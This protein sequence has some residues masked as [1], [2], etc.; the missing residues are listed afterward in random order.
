[1]KPYKYQQDSIIEILEG[2]K[3]NQR[4]CYSLATGG[5]KTALFSFLAKEFIGKSDK[6]V[7]ILAHRSKLIDQTVNTLYNIGVRSESIISKKKYL[8]HS[9][10]VYVSMVETLFNRLKKNPYFLPKIDLLIVD[11]AHILT[12]VKVIDLLLKLNP[13][14]KILGVTATPSTTITEKT[15]RLLSDGSKM[16]YTQK[17]GLHKH[18]GDLIEGLGIQFLIEQGSIVPEL[19]FN[20][21]HI[22]R[23]GLVFDDKKNEFKPSNNHTEKFCVLTHYEKFAKGKKTIIFTASTKDNL[24]LLEEFESK[25]YENVRIYDS[26]NKEESGDQ[27]E[28]LLWYKNTQDAILINTSV[29]T[30]GFDEPTIECVILALATAS[31]AK[32]HQMV[33]RGGRSTKKMFKD[34]FLLIDLGGNIDTFGKWSDPVDWKDHFYYKSKCLP[35]K[36]ALDRIAFCENCD[37][38]IPMTA[39][40]CPFC[41]HEKPKKEIALSKDTVHVSELIYPD[42]EKIV[43]YCQLYGKDKNFA[44]NILFSQCIDLFQYTEISLEKVENTIKNGNFFKTMK[45]VM[46][47]QV[48]FIQNSNLQGDY[49]KNHLTEFISNLYDFYNKK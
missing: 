18:Y 40:E 2:F 35:K 21:K 9:A 36:E 37:M 3:T 8:N 33:G 1:M 10:Q 38:I 28:L 27:D 43:R 41:G 23:E 31:L 45:I 14:M 22:K 6:R 20:N 4:L 32:Y 16:E 29:F 12:F 13:E 15:T 5:G 24:S 30:T 11:E 26:V 47:E 19:I 17:F 34:K 49:K 48:L 25:G 44:I 46:D 42:G 39:V 7:T